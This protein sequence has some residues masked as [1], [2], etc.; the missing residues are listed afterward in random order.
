[1]SF[2]IQRFAEGQGFN[3]PHGVRVMVPLPD[4]PCDVV[5]HHA[6]GDAVVEKVDFIIGILPVGVF[7]LR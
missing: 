2:E 4:E 3:P 5:G 6:V 7:P 1:L